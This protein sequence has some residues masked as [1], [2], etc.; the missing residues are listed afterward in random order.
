MTGFQRMVAILMGIFILFPILF[1]ASG[2]TSF[3][4]SKVK[5]SFGPTTTDKPLQPASYTS[6]ISDDE[7]RLMTLNRTRAKAYVENAVRDY[8]TGKTE[9]ALRR[10]ERAKEFDPSSYEALRLSGQIMFEQN[11]YRKAFN[12]WARATQLPNDDRNVARDLDVVKRLI[13]YCR[14]E[15]DRLQSTVNKHPDNLIAL[16]KL[17]E[18]KARVAE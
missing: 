5:L 12:E 9:E 10:L 11:N 7:I 6:P 1:Y 14:H 2:F 3:D 8:Y 16:E 4:L 18:L 15:I 13:R 17:K